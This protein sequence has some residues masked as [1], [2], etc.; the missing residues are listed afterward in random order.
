MGIH[1]WGPTAVPNWPICSSPMNCNAVLMQLGSNALALAAHP[2]ISQYE[3]CRAYDRS[4][5]FQTI[6]AADCR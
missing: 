4:L 2:G 1:R 5:V 6:D 3:S